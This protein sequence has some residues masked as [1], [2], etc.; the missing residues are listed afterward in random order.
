MGEFPGMLV[1]D[2]D[3]PAQ[4]RIVLYRCQDFGSERLPVDRTRRSNSLCKPA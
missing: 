3:G 1:W 2:V 4:P